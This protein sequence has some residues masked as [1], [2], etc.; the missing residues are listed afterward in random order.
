MDVVTC[1]RCSVKTVNVRSL[2]RH[3]GIRH[4]HERDFSIICGID[5]CRKFYRIFTTFKQHVYR[6]HRHVILQQTI[7]ASECMNE[8]ADDIDDVAL[9]TPESSLVDITTSTVSESDVVK[10]F[11]LFC[12]KLK[13][14]HGVTDTVVSTVVNDMCDLMKQSCETY[15]QQI[16]AELNKSNVD[17]ESNASLM[18][19][20]TDAPSTVTAFETIFGTSK[21]RLRFYTAHLPLILPQEIS[22]GTDV[23]GKND[24]F[25]YIPVLEVLKAWLSHTCLNSI[26]MNANRQPS[27]SMLC[28]AFD[29]SLG[30]TCDAF[31]VVNC[32][33][34]LLYFDDFEVANPL[35]SKRGKYKL[36]AVYFTILNIPL[37]YRSKLENMQLVLL[38]KSKH[39][40]KYGL[41]VIFAPLINDLK[42]LQPPGINV[43]I[44]GVQHHFS[45]RLALVC[46][47]N[48][49]AN[50]VAGFTQ[51]FSRGRICRFCMATREEISS[52]HLE[53]M[54][55][56]RTAETHQQHINAVLG[57]KSLSSV[58]GVTSACP[59]SGL[60]GFD[61]TST[62]T[63]DVMHDVL[64]GV[65]PLTVKHILRS[66]ISSGSVS[67]EDINSRIRSLPVKYGKELYL[68][69]PLTS[70]A[71]KGDST[72]S[73]NASEKWCLLRILPFLVNDERS[74]IV[75][76]TYECLREVADIVLARR[77]PQAVIG[78][79]AVCISSFLQ[80]FLSAFPEDAMTPKMHFLVHYPRYIQLIGPLIGV[81]T[82]RFEGKHFPLKRTAQK[83]RNW[84][85]VS[86]SL[87]TSHQLMQCYAFSSESMFPDSI[88]TT[89]SRLA[90]D[91]PS[92]LQTVLT[93]TLPADDS[94]A[95]KMWQANSVSNGLANIQ[96]KHAYLLRWNDYEMP[97]FW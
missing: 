15:Q 39:V 67:V 60:S 59:F 53:S 5:G 26:V 30:S 32:L 66:V 13:E 11:G 71:I 65:V 18:S 61:V 97:V 89:G 57:D 42:V 55:R 44:S 36:F 63:P 46:A 45:A 85:N 16:M 72:L 37:K 40:E 56:L 22:L 29:G 8:H 80:N 90:T 21:N 38:A 91:L 78:F 64:E 84:T 49:A 62:F 47:D 51:N 35:G 73:G 7:A 9:P 79:L 3:I 28:D 96:C 69:Q 17:V 41:D 87:A 93:E 43:C 19:L 88:Q 86:M 31:S 76:E 81:W 83:I 52:L 95:D 33:Q 70:A 94:S 75:W 92:E 6:N 1:P 50:K 54:C 14:K 4:S 20:L 12:L 48:L 2:I 34:L 74:G 25:A 23:R 68:P 82:M 10:S 77:V 27:N 58:Y 24:T